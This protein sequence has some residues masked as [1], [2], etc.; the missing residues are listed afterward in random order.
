MK[1]FVVAAILLVVG[2][3]QAGLVMTI[4]TDNKNFYFEGSDEGSGSSTDE[5]FYLI[6]FD[7]ARACEFG[8]NVDLDLSGAFDGDYVFNEMY[9]TSSDN[10]EISFL[11]AGSDIT[12]LTGTGVSGAVSYSTL[13]TS[14]QTVFESMAGDSFSIITGSGYSDI[15]VQTIPE[16][17]TVGLLVVAGG[18]L[19]LRRNFMVCRSVLRRS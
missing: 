13:S 14:D 8:N 1:K 2:V 11:R 3:A 17:A 16:A 10:T 15:S 7:T 5:F 4:D 9:L 19:C 12:S 18:I 6:E